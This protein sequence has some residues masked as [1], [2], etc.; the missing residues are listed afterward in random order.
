[1]S[2][3]HLDQFAHVDSPVTRRSP[4]VRLLGVVILAGGA[5]VLPLGAWPQLA[6][7]ALLV[8]G[9]AALARIGPGSFLARFLPPFTFVLL[10]SV[11]LLVLAPGQ[12]VAHVG[13]LR[14][15]D[16]GALRFGSVAGRAAV[17]LGAA[18]ILVCTTPFPDVLRGLRSLRLPRVVTT[19]LALAYRYLY[20]LTD[21]V[22]R[23]RRAARSRNAG[24]GA[25]SRRRLLVG[26][27]A[28]A[29]G[30]SFSRSERLY[31]AMLSR[32][33]AGDVPTLGEPSWSGR[34]RLEVALLALMVALVVGSA[35]L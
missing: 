23:L 8:T 33:Y 11:A 1:M 14:I 21:E 10:V 32:G 5:A 9:L 16:A 13:P 28:A 3:R 30:R 27:T 29:V 6:V 22:G 7:L 26:I 20:V 24:A 35:S 4:T 15:T 17:A 2:F 25:V 34:P 18:V 31:Q 12:T 19:S